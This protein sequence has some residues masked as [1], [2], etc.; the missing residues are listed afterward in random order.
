MLSRTFAAAV[1]VSSLAYGSSGQAQPIPVPELPLGTYCL[2]GD[3]PIDIL[4]TVRNSVDAIDAT[5]EATFLETFGDVEV[6]TR[7]YHGDQRIHMIEQDVISHEYASFTERYF[8]GDGDI[9]CG[10]L[11]RI[12]R[13]VPPEGGPLQPVQTSIRIA[14][15][16]GL[17]VERDGRPM[18]LDDGSAFA[19]EAWMAGDDLYHRFALAVVAPTANSRYMAL[20]CKDI[21]EI[22]EMDMGGVYDCGSMAGYDIQLVEDDLRQALRL[23]RNGRTD[24]LWIDAPG[25]SRFGP[26]L[27][28]RG[29]MDANGTFVADSLIVRVFLDHDDGSVTQR[30]AVGRLTGDNACFDGWV[31]VARNPD[32]NLDARLLADSPSLYVIPC[33]SGT[34]DIQQ[35]MSG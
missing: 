1:A 26:M 17:W 25:F 24:T 31:E 16:V 3:L 6:I 15:E 27:E 29:E 20:D 19:D 5:E 7:L 32:H 22:F 14:P 11:L 35:K 13:E 23:T 12:D 8:Y 18:V 30:L 28:W 34:D 33:D 21:L 4:N 2:R 9:E 10:E